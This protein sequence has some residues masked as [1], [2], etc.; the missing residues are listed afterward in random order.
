MQHN[1]RLSSAWK[2]KLANRLP[3][4]S[5]ALFAVSYMLD[6]ERLREHERLKSFKADSGKHLYLQH[7]QSRNTRLRPVLKRYVSAGRRPITITQPRGRGL[8]AS[9]GVMVL[10]NTHGLPKPGDHV[11]A[12]GARC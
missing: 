10:K 12:D 2:S 6:F 11:S 3:N 4:E 9:C 5:P 1:T 8:H 7:T